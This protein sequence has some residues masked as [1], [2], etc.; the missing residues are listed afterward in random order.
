M[1]FYPV[2]LRAVIVI[3]IWH[4]TGCRFDWHIE[5]DEFGKRIRHDHQHKRECERL[6][7]SLFYFSFIFSFSP[8]LFTDFLVL[9]LLFARGPN[10]REFLS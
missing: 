1:G 3:G 9:S 5:F 4:G 2:E 10:L 8:L 6:S 7:R